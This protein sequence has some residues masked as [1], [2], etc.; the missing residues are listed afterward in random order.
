MS[1]YER[2][3][4]ERLAYAH[5]YY[6]AHRSERLAYGK[7][8]REA[9]CVELCE[10]Y[11]EYH[12]G[13]RSEDYARSKCWREKN[14]AKHRSQSIVRFRRWRARHYDKHRAIKLARY[15]FPLGDCCEFCGSTVDLMRFLVEYKVSVDFVVTV[16]RSCRG[17]ARKSLVASERHSGSEQRSELNGIG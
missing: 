2:H 12:R 11:R 10:Y 8:W 4:A 15:H 14:L 5:R 9:H 7:R 1:Y 13:H 16:C 3:R 17:Y 6:L